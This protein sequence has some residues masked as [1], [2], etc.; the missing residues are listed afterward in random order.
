M[1]TE[2]K[3]SVTDVE[4]YVIVTDEG[5]EEEPKIEDEINV[6]DDGK[7]SKSLFLPRRM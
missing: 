5:V 3:Y 2:G 6:V 7:E 4:N 1:E